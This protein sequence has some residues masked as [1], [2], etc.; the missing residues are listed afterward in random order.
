MKL[1]GCTDSVDHISHT[2]YH[3]G[4]TQPRNDCISILGQA[5][6]MLHI[7]YLFCER[8]R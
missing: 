2:H 3:E 7:N 4:L 6:H 8:K 5:S 1:T